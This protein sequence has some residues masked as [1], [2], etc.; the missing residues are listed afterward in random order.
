VEVGGTDV[1]VG[2]AAWVCVINIHASATAVFAW[3]SALRVGASLPPQAEINRMI[4]I[5]I[6]IKDFCF[7]GSPSL[8]FTMK[9]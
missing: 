6:V 8:I 9:H 2:N 3:S 1:D 4:K 7:I 5:E